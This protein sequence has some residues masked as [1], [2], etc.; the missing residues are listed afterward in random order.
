LL[1][2]TVA[3][4]AAIS[5]LYQAGFY[6]GYNYR[7]SQLLSLKAG[8]DAVYY[9]RPF[10]YQNFYST[11]QES[12]TSFDHFSVGLSIGTDVWLGR[13]AFMFNYGYYL[14]YAA[15]GPTHTYW[16]IGGKY[17]LNSWMALNAK[18]YIHGL[19]A[20]YANF[21]LVFNVD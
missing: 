8:T 13:M 12:G 20:H 16:I 9:F 10:S 21:G 6:A 19:E 18:I 1:T 5:H 4:K 11:Y 2:D 15:T 14:H 7:L 3:Q 17:Y